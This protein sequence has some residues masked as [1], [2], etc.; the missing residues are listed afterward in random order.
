MGDFFNWLTTT[1]LGVL[2]LCGMLFVV[3]AVFALIYELRTRKEFP[4]RA[5]RN[6]KKKR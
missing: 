2:A 3:F 1:P 4:D 6:S 5:R